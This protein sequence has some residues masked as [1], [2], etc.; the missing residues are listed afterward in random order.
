[1]STYDTIIIGAGLSGLAAGIRLAH[2]GKKVVI[3]EKHSL[4]GGLNSWYRRGGRQFD[5]G[6]HAITNFTAPDKASAPL[7]KLLRQLRLRREELEMCPQGFS[8]IDFPGVSLR[9]SNEFAEFEAAVSEAFPKEIDGFRK[10]VERI[11]ATDSL[12]PNA[13]WESAR[14]VL[15]DCLKNPVL[16]DMILEPVMYYGSA[17]PEDMDFNQFCIMFQSIFLEGFWRPA[18]GMRPLLERLVER[19]KE[20][21]G[22]LRMNSPVNLLPLKNGGVS[23]VIL[24]S[25]EVLTA[26]TILSSAGAVETYLLCDPLPEIAGIH[27]PG[28]LSY[29]ETLFVLDR[30]PAELGFAST[31]SFYNANEK[32][33]Y[34]PPAAGAVDHDSGVLCVPGNFR[35]PGGHDPEP[36]LRLTNQASFNA[37]R[38]LRGDKYQAKKAEV[39]QRQT[40]WLDRRS[41]G[42]SSHVVATDMFTPQTVIRY[43]GHMHGAI[44]G[45]PRKLRDGRTPFKNL[46]LCG[47][48][49][50][51][52]GIVGSMLSGVSMANAHLLL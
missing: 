11:R 12:S 28:R 14:A 34:Q 8:S 29:V 4:P 25:K 51:F 13:K 38:T 27:P 35:Y 46:Y 10:L 3:L 49:Q 32:F 7:N 40:E 52:L 1:M 39:L 24:E 6:L 36:L 31:I 18:G 21:G 22:E 23:E 17:E 5:V 9:F 43:T 37:W 47:T 50:G 26:K 2:Y 41:P 15:G 30:P 20:C 16:A 33:R 48:D 42:F 19:Y 44:Y 45:S